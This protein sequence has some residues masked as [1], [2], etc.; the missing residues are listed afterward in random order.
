[1]KR[2]PLITKLDRL[3]LICMAL[4]IGVMIQPWWQA[5]FRVGFF[6]TL[7]FTLAQIVTSHMSP[8]SSE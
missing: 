1:M 8:R 5:G 3:T 2:A 7:A 4:G 6:L